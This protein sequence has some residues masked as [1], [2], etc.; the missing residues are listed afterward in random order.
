MRHLRSFLDGQWVQGFVGALFVAVFC[1]GGAADPYEAYYLKLN[2]YPDNSMR[3]WNPNGTET[4]GV[5]HDDDNWYFTSTDVDGSNGNL[6]R[7]PVSADLRQNVSGIPGTAKISMTDIPALRAANYWHWGDVDRF[8]HEDVDYL[9]VAMTSDPVA[10][11][12]MTDADCT[13]GQTCECLPFLGCSCRCSSD[14]NCPL[15]TCENTLCKARPAIAFFRA[16]PLA[17]VDFEVLAD[18]ES[19]GWCAMHPD[20]SLY[21]S[22]HQ[23]D[24]TSADERNHLRRYHIDWPRVTD[25]K[26]HDALTW[27]D[28][29]QLRDADGQLLFLHNMQGG[30]F[31]E[32]G[33]LLYI[34]S[35]SGFCENIFGIGGGAGI[36]ET[37]GIHVFETAT[38]REVQRSTNR[39]REDDY[40]CSLDE[41]VSCPGVFPFRE[42]GYCSDDPAKTCVGNAQTLECGT[43]SMQAF[44]I[45][46]DALGVCE[47]GY[48]DYSFNNGCTCE[49]PFQFTAGSQTPEGLTI[50]DLDNRGAPGIRGQLHVAVNFY[51]RYAACDDAISLHHF[52]RSLNVD[53]MN[54][55]SP[56]WDHPLPGT[57]FDLANEE[58][59]PFLTV[60]EAYTFY[61]IWDGAELVIEAGFYPETIVF[62]KRIR[63]VA[64]GG[65][66][67]IGY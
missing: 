11:M 58:G 25:S 8:R 42:C 49:D 53:K 1:H 16:S 51:N 19:A 55:A 17:F 23:L 60:N 59:R 22:V 45:P 61:P 9:L 35:G 47:S 13:T 31:T 20:G 10:P 46:D 33:Q 50:W 21:T 32:S 3:D 48:F 66:A 56:E 62:S 54:G 63:V 65:T 43:P 6:W 52:T 37:D 29:Y 26:W 5:A 44:C 24:S 64:H 30:E 7:I 2:S 57:P 40:V 41:S 67:I 4:Q 14:A 36:F 15:G 28:T 39:I 27:E 34:S 18:Q 38:W 12:C